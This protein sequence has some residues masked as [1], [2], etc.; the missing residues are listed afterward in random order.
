MN[1]GQRSPRREVDRFGR[2]P[3]RRPHIQILS[4]R[5]QDALRNIPRNTEDDDTSAREPSHVHHS[6][7]PRRRPRSAPHEEVY[8]GTRAKRKARPYSAF[9]RVP[10]TA[11]SARQ[12]PDM[13]PLER[14]THSWRQTWVFGTTYPAADRGAHR[15]YAVVTEQVG[16]HQDPAETSPRPQDPRV[17][18]GFRLGV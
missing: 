9:P 14:A 7:L 5:Q 15:W 13:M 10:R 18:R 3:L 4:H 2:S 12:D 16:H 11:R 1:L 8:Q 17:S 6:P